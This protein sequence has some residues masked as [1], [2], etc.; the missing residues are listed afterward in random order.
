MQA[1][2]DG[3]PLKMHALKADDGDPDPIAICC[4]GML[5]NDTKKVMLRFAEDRPIGEVPL[6][7]WNGYARGYMKRVRSGSS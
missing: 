7:S 1:W 6:C 3:P 2:A 5:R 4:Y